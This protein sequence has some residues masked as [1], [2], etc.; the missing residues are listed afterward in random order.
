[1]RPALGPPWEGPVATALCKPGRYPSIEASLA[2][3]H[4]MKTRMGPP[5]EDLDWGRRLKALSG[6]NVFKSGWDPPIEDLVWVRFER[7]WSGPLYVS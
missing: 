3:V 2:G 4:S 7:A 1:M 6:P 5:Y